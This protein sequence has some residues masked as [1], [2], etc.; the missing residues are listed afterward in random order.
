MNSAV[1]MRANSS[2]ARRRSRYSGI[3][4]GSFAAVGDALEQV[5]MPIVGSVPADLVDPGDADLGAF[6]EEAIHVVAGTGED[7]SE[8]KET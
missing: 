2:R 8:V 4:P 7:S 3:G 1:T 5:E 6:G